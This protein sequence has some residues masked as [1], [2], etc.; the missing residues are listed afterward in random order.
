MQRWFTFDFNHFNWWLGSAID[1]IWCRI[2][3]YVL[4]FKIGDFMA[5]KFVFGNCCRPSD[6]NKYFWFISYLLLG[7]L[8]INNKMQNI[9]SLIFLFRYE[10]FLMTKAFYSYFEQFCIGFF[11]YWFEFHWGHYIRFFYKKK[12]FKTGSI[13]NLVFWILKNCIISSTY[14]KLRRQL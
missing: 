14:L 1:C 7:I 5:H 9:N 12:Q 11:I 10:Q 3:I 4:L 6:I 13:R 8:K 2:I